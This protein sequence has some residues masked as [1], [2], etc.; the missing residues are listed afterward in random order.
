LILQASG[1]LSLTPFLIALKLRGCKI[2]K[3]MQSSFADEVST[4]HFCPCATGGPRWSACDGAGSGLLVWGGQDEGGSR[5]LFP[6]ARGLLHG[7]P[8][9]RR[10]PQQQPRAQDQPGDQ[11]REQQPGPIF[12]L[13]LRHVVVLLCDHQ[14]A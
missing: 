2:N 1:L 9:G 10:Q 5:P 8:L 3:S 12:L 11:G 13:A 7:S 14:G 4:A 6:R